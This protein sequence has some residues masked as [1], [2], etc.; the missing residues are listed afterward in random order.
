MIQRRHVLGMGA[1]AAGL[2][3][4][5]PAF[6]GTVWKQ[7]NPHPEGYPSVVAMENFG[8]KLAAATHGRLSTQMYAAM[9]LGAEKETIQQAQIGAIQMLPASVGALAAVVDQLN[10]FNL[11]FVFRSTAQMQRVVDGKVGQDLLD[12][13]TNNPNSKLVGLAWIDAGA[14]SVYDTRRPIHGL[15]DL[16]GLKM[17]VIQNPIF[18]AMMNAMG[19]NAISMGYDQVFSALQ[20]GVIDGAENN[21]PSYVFDHHYE[22]AKHYTFTEHLILPEVLIFSRATWDKLSKPDQELVRH[23]AKET[24]AEARALWALKD[25]A[26]LAKMIEAKIDIVHLKDKTEF[27]RA[28]QPVWKKYGTK[29]E[30]MIKRIQAVA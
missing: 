28:V 21:L 1:A 13:I 11:P 12:T 7:A 5:T 25:K 22:A 18:L 20:T 30:A 23:L 9:Q 2:A 10:V 15:K 24:Q 27:V 16:K 14:R 26:A 8:K 17:R 6:A 3:A 19:A 4:A 29:Y